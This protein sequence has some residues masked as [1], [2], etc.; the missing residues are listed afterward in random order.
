[1]KSTG[2]WKMS[3][4]EKDR[5]HQTRKVIEQYENPNKDLE[6]LENYKKYIVS[7]ERLS[8]FTK[9]LSFA[10]DDSPMPSNGEMTE[11]GR[12]VMGEVVLATGV[13][14]IVVTR[15]T[16]GSYGDKMAGFNPR[17]ISNDDCVVEEEQDDHK[18]FRRVNPSLPPKH[19][20]CE[21]QAAEKTSICSVY[22]EN[23]C[24]PDG[25]NILVTWDKTHSTNGS[26]Y[27]HLTRPLKILLD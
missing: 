5:A 14:P 12:I 6:I 2:E 4:Q 8:D 25:F 16:I 18:I 17:E 27:L 7:S 13:R 1:M 20:A 22:C 15:L 3:N 11:L 23:R 24:D 9:V 26:S 19:K 21:H 10:A